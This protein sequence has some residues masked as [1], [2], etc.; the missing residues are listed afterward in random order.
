MSSF[1]FASVLARTSL[2]K[3]TLFERRKK[4]TEEKKKKRKRKE[5][6]RKEK[7]RKRN[8]DLSSFL[9]LN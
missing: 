3:F 1:F 2:I 4:D 8:K 6:K 7:K 5:K 9:E